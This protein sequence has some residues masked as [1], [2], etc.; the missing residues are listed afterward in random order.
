MKFVNIQCPKIENLI[1]LIEAI[2]KAAI[3]GKSS[4]AAFFKISSKTPS[5]PD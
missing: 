5:I 1:Q 2:L 3:E 4:M